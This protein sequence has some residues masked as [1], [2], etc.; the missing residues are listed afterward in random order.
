MDIIFAATL[1]PGFLQVRFYNLRSHTLQLVEV[2]S[3]QNKTGPF[4][5]TFKLG[6]VTYDMTSGLVD[7]TSGG[8]A[9]RAANLTSGIA[10]AMLFSL[11]NPWS[12]RGQVRE[13][14]SPESEQLHPVTLCFKEKCNVQQLDLF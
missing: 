6:D 8:G 13:W 11:C 1:N 14:I 4:N 7:M 3:R 12:G 5:F 10:V 9:N 2:P